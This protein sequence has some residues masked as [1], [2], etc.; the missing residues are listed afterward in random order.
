MTA[1]V[2]TS[3]TLTIAG[4]RID[5]LPERAAYWPS[6]QT[7]IL[8]DVHLGKCETL[9][10][11][12]VPVPAGI[13]ERDLDRLAAAAARAHA[14]RILVV[15]DLLHH[16]TGLTP[17]FIETVAEVRRGNLGG[18]EI[19]L[20]RGNHDRRVEAILDAWDVSL[21]PAAH[22]EGPFGFAHDPADGLVPAAACT[23]FGHLHPLCR[24]GT[25]ADGV[26]IPCFVVDSDHVLLP[27]FSLFTRGVAIV[28]RRTAAAYGIA[29]GRVVLVPTVV[30]GRAEAASC[31]NGGQR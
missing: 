24:I 21:L 12:G 28:P 6:R 15:G 23:W 26:S 27:A 17:E 20:I 25:R 1:A 11:A 2:H 10:A 4:E 9:R 22:L 31:L 29:D 13:V 7:L 16:S 30:S 3:H 5:L 14:T 18:V 19:G 8:A